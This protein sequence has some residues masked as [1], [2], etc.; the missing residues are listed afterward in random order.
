VTSHVS[1]PLPA[2]AA[3]AVLQVVQDEDLPGRARRAGERLLGHLQELQRRHEAVGDVRGVG[4]LCGL[5]LVE[6]RDSRRPAERLGLELGE[7]CERRGL[8]INLVRGGTGGAANCL[9]MAPP[10]TV[11]DDEIDLAADILDSSLAAV[12]SATL[13]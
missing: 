9:R 4:L 13:H 5:E 10:L 6:D 1:D 8:S 12:Q 2:A 11:S 3:Q 7:E